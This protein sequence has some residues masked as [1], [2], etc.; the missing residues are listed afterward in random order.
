MGMFG[1]ELD[2]EKS[3]TN[4]NSAG[5]KTGSSKTA[6]SVDVSSTINSG[7]TD[8]SVSE[9]LNS[10]RTDTSTTDQTTTNSGRTDTSN[11][12]NSGRVDVNST[13]NSGRV[14]SGTSNT[15]TSGRTDTSTT[16]A[17]VNTIKTDQTVTNS[18]RVDATQTILTQSAVERLLQQLMEGNNGLQAVTAGQRASGGYDSTASTLLTNDLA[19]RV[20]GEV[21]VRGAVTE[22]RIGGSTTTTSGTQ[23]ENIGAINVSNVIGATSSNTSFSNI[24]GA[25]SSVNT[26]VIGESSSGTTNTIGASSSNTK[27]FNQNIIG[28]SSV[29]SNATN[30]IGGTTSQTTVNKGATETDYYENETKK[31]ETNNTAVKTKAK[32]S[33]ICTELTRTGKLD[34][35]MY[36]LSHVE[37]Q[38]YPEYVTN[39]YYYW[40]MPVLEKLRAAP[41]GK[42]AKFYTW[43]LNSRCRGIV[44]RQLKRKVY[45]YDKAV[46]KV[47]YGICAV[48][49]KTVARKFKLTE[50]MYQFILGDK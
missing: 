47:T 11:T 12:V 23:T 40:A 28:E 45:W 29:K 36:I 1:L 3:K 20:A 15:T 4:S 48:L 37:F 32:I 34:R 43:L 38:K 30:T 21:A 35:T 39:G 9:V 41:T 13:V 7:R 16:D 17:R 25:S 31:V 50:T 2:Y 18:G 46:A 10:G 26:N 24:I 49:G 22:N 6:A 33:I 19:A 44:G 27:G 14:D 8:T 5:T 42:T